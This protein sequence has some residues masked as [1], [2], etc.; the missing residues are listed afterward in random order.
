MSKRES[1]QWSPIVEF[2]IH[3]TFGCA[4]PIAAKSTEEA[5]QK[6]KDYDRYMDGEVPRSLSKQV[7]VWELAHQFPYCCALG[8]TR[9]TTLGDHVGPKECNLF[10]PLDPGYPN[11]KTKNQDDTWI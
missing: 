6:A 1:Y 5:I 9:C 10:H 8:D 11:D 4:Y 3:T 2:M 7:I